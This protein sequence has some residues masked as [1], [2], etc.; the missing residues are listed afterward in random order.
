MRGSACRTAQPRRMTVGTRARRPRLVS[1]VAAV[2][3]AW[4]N[5]NGGKVNQ[6]P[7]LR[8]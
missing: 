4:L 2:P 5:R 1:L 6:H 8:R 3:R 7:Y